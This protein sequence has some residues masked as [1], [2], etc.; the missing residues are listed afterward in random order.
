MLKIRLLGQ[1]DVRLNGAPVEIPSRP[2]QSLLAKLVLTAG[3]AHRREKLAGELWPD[4]SESNARSNLRHALWRIR[5]AME[6]TEQGQSAHNKRNGKGKCAGDYI[7]ADGISIAFNAQSNFWVDAREL[8]QQL[9]AP[10]TCTN[11]LALS[12]R[13]YEGELLPGVYDE[14]AGPHRMR[15]QIAFDSLMNKLLTNLREEARWRDAVEMC[16][17]WIA[18]GDSQ[19]TA[20]RELM[21]AHCALGD[22]ASMQ[23]DFR[24]LRAQMKQQFGI[25]PSDET[26]ALFEQ[27]LNGKQ[28]RSDTRSLQEARQPAHGKSS[29]AKDAVLVEPKPP[30]S[31]HG[32][33]PS[34][35]T[36]Q[37]STTDYLRQIATAQV[38]AS[39]SAPTITSLLADR[40]WRSTALTGYERLSMPA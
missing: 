28:G 33:A 38:S 7:I 13:L 25:A 21:V 27:L 32:H 35:A 6:T 1:F 14:W 30:A 10:R 20:Y 24:A 2:A 37:T 39:G 17:H 15:L 29:F 31:G 18:C 9:K 19:E 11:A 16:G 3:T 22:L 8:E 36:T 12:A 26:C 5:K 34:A 4:A 40:H 23:S